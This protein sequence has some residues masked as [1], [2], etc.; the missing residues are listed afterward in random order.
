MN[1][2]RIKEKVAFMTVHGSHLYGLAHENSD[3]DLMI[4]YTYSR[5]ALHLKR[6]KDDVIHVGLPNLIEYAQSGAH[7][8]VE[9]L[10]SQQ[11]IW[12]NDSWKTFVESY[13]IP[14]AQIAEKYERT[15]KRLC[16]DD[17][18]L[19]RHAVRLWCNLKD[20]RTEQGGRFNP[21][22]SRGDILFASKLATDFEGA[23]LK[24]FLLPSGLK[25]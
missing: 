12:Y 7:Q 5:P 1:E 22:L 17:F 20:L 4:V 9:G 2:K 23:E 14:A 11:K 6:G 21:T 16:F 18:K 19:R 10:F 13:Q 25:V 24:E 3:N 8:F 15:I